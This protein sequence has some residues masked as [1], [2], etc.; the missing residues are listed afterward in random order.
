LPKDTTK[1]PEPFAKRVGEL[2]CIVGHLLALR[3]AYLA[4]DAMAIIA[5]DDTTWEP[6]MSFIDANVLLSRKERNSTATLP[7][8]TLDFLKRAVKCASSPA[9]QRAS[10]RSWPSSSHQ[11]GAAISCAEAAARGWANQPV[12]VQLSTLNQD[13][14]YQKHVQELHSLGTDCTDERKSCRFLLHARQW[15]HWGTQGLL[16]NRA[17]IEYFA[18]LFWGVDTDPTLSTLSIPALLP[19][20]QLESPAADVLFYNLPHPFGKTSMLSFP[21]TIHVP[22]LATQSALWAGVHHHVSHTE[23]VWE[24][25]WDAANAYT[26]Y[27]ANCN[28]D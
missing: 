22:K 20:L 21:A 16:W 8:E 11:E 5:E 2:G 26:R 28:A 6:L 17:A 10:G 7:R 19:P 3:R 15:E 24:R 25:S 14:V 12:V 9:E 1:H 4:G 23:S 18:H 13:G 27:V